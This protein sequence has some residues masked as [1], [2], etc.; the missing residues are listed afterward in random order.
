MLSAAPSS[1]PDEDLKFSHLTVFPNGG[2]KILSAMIHLLGSSILGYCIACRIGAVR[3]TSVAE[4]KAL[5]WP[6]VCVL[7]ILIVSWLFIF[8]A[9]ILIHGVGMASSFDA[10]SAG[11]YLCTFLY[12]ISKLLIYAFLIEKVRVVWDTVSQPR[13]RSPVYLVCLFI[14]LPFFVV[15]ILMIVGRIA[16]FRSD[17]SC[18]IGLNT[19]SGFSLLSY[20]LCINV[21]LNG[22]FL[23][24]LLRYKLIN[25]RLR[26]VGQRTLIAA[27]VALA[28]S[29]INIA[30]LTIMKGQL[31]WVCLGSCGTDVA[32]NAIVIFWVTSP[33]ADSP[34]VSHSIRVQT[35]YLPAI[36]KTI[37]EQPP[38]SPAPTSPSAVFAPP[39]AYLPRTSVSSP[40]RSSKVFEVVRQ[41]TISEEHDLRRVQELPTFGSIA[42]P[43]SSSG[44]L[45]TYASSEEQ[46][47]GTQHHG[48]ASGRKQSLRGLFGLPT[49]Q[50]EKDVEVHV[51]VVTQ[52]EVELGNLG[53]ERVHEDRRSVEEANPTSSRHK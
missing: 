53:S 27:L 47:P 3:V 40:M 13:L 31:G 17:M 30:T 12:A 45:S 49:K 24:P 8:G 41:R 34:A 50:K 52:H 42:T 29:I 14:M 19:F 20:D 4:L 23:W 2:T 21:F 16:Y 6:R 43:L 44:A 35:T 39:A 48:D 36:D 18:V 38:H 25:P 37:N 7:F 33:M 5:S 32:L 22:M 15:P 26:A 11:I 9:G 1:I 28:T 51:S 46:E 10:C